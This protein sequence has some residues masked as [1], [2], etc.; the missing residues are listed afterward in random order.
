MVNTFCHSDEVCHANKHDPVEKRD[1]NTYH[2]RKNDRRTA[3]ESHPRHDLIRD[4]HQGLDS[5]SKLFSLKHRLRSSS[6]WKVT[7]EL[8]TEVRRLTRRDPRPA[9]KYLALI[10]KEP[11]DF[12]S[13]GKSTVCEIGNKLSF[14]FMEADVTFPFTTEQKATQNALILHLPARQ[15]D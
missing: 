14:L 7:S 1:P 6:P 8:I 4:I 11:G 3:S 15:T 5:A 13:L 10:L 12:S 9:C 2:W